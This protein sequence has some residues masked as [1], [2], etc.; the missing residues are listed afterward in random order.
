M[1]RLLRTKILAVLSFYCLVLTP[2]SAARFP[3]ALEGKITLNGPE[4]VSIAELFGL[5]SPGPAKVNLPLGRGDS[6]AVY[7]LKQDVEPP[8][9]NDNQGSPARE[10]LLQ[11]DSSARPSLSISPYW[12]DLGSR[13]PDPKPGFYSFASPLVP[14]SLKGDGEWTKLLRR[15][16]QNALWNE[17]TDDKVLFR[18][19]FSLKNGDTMNL[20]VYP[21]QD[22]HDKK[23][24]Y[25]VVITVHAIMEKF[26]ILPHGSGM[27][28]R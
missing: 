28:Q 8:L 2:A 4:A 5:V 3:N 6:W 14:S 20:E 17:K 18:R 7:L 10:N 26:Q 25:K 19:E 21:D 12:L 9:L 22:F 23:K 1:L 24:G 27:N 16:K 15:L 13:A 11:F